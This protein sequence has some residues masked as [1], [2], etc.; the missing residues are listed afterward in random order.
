MTELQQIIEAAFE[1]RDTITPG[2][3]DS[4]T[5]SAILQAIDLLDSGK[6]RV[7]EKIAGEWVVHQWLKKAV[8][9][10]FRINDNGII[11]GDDAQY[12]D[13]VPLKFS[14]YTAEQ[15]KEAGVRVVPPATAR[16]GSF[17]APNTVL[18]PSYV[19]IGAFVDE[20]TMVD[21]WATVGS[22]AQIGKN[23]HLSGGVGIGGVL[24]P[25]QANP[26]IIEDNCF[27][28]A[29]SEVV[30]GVIVEEGS[31]ISMGVFIG[32]STRIYDRETGEIH[33]GRVPA[34]SV[35]VS[36]SLPSKCGK[37]SLYAAVIVKKVDAKTRA[38]VGINALLRSIDE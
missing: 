23:V 32:Q 30:E 25:L 24:E 17:I 14:N 1:R 35:V 10:Y 26:T 2:S 5:K 33:Y 15:F 29:R 4:A 28:G 9:L 3:V 13:K 11:K 19:N 12:Y 6:V 31:V 7:A 34:G 20:G 18:M 8:L 21:T 27:I 37:Y 16:K 36:G 38:K 22:C